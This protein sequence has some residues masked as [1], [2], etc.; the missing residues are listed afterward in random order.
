MQYNES[1]RIT[2]LTWSTQSQIISFFKIGLLYRS[3]ATLD[4][5]YLNWK[6]ISF[7]LIL[8]S[9]ALARWSGFPRLWDQRNHNYAPRS[10]DRMNTPCFLFKLVTGCPMAEHSR[11]ISTVN[12]QYKKPSACRD[13]FNKRSLQGPLIREHLSSLTKGCMLPDWGNGKLCCPETMS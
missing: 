8:I 13:S 3:G 5:R 2:K 4:L 6:M 12:T 7:P 11:D 9:T 10:E 1:A